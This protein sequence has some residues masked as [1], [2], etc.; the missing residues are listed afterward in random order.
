WG[1]GW[2]SEEKFQH[3][4][5]AAYALLRKEE[6]IDPRK[7]I[8]IGSSIG[9]GIAAYT[10]HAYQV[11]VL[12]LLS[13]YTSLRNVVAE[14]PVVGAL[15]PFLR[16][17][18]PTQDFLSKINDAC[19]IIAHGR[20]DSTIPFSHSEKLSSLY[21]GRGRMLFLPSSEAGHN[22]LLARVNPE[23][24]QAMLRCL[25]DDASQGPRSSE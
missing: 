12:V 11:G 14:M 10:A 17:D 1:S 18:F 2:P 9:T 8:V 13:P 21:S 24:A 23:L 5:G 16:Y 6:S 7:I 22:D 4:A 20:R 3:D 25:P 15:S 19:L